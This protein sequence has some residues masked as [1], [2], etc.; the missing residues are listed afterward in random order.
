[1]LLYEVYSRVLRYRTG[2]TVLA[3]SKSDGV[4]RHNNADLPV[5]SVSVLIKRCLTS[6]PYRFSNKACF[7]CRK[8]GHVLADCPNRVTQGDGICFK[9]GS[10]EHNIYKCPRKHIKGGVFSLLRLDVLRHADFTP[11]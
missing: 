11:N 2:P 10:T 3:T 9:C 6:T 4:Q 7:H 1:M 5:I 8:Q